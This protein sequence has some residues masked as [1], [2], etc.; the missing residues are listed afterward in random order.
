MEFYDVGKVVNTHGLKGEVRVISVTTLPEARYQ[1][2]AS[3]IW[4]GKDGRQEELTVRTHRKHKT[5]D[6]LAFDEY[7]NINQ[8]EQFVGGTLKVSE[9]D[10]LELPEN[11]F[12]VHELIG[13][14]VI[15]NDSGETIGKIK[16][17]LSPGANDVWVVQRQ[18]QK[19]LLLPYIEPVILDVD[20][21]TGIVKVHVMEGLDE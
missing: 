11:E 10:L 15:D 14:T 1:K 6:L 7:F 13:L 17:V 9:E 19:D 21:E 20:F 3:L 16:E 8:V 2:G 4:F 12:Y 5:F 18:G